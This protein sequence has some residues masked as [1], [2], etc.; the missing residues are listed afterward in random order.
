[1]KTNKLAF[2]TKDQNHSELLSNN[3]KTFVKEARWGNN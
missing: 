3:H 1:M 2:P